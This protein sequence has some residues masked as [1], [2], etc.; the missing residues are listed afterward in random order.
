MVLPAAI[1]IRRHAFRCSTRQLVMLAH[2]DSPGHSQE[3]QRKH[4]VGMLASMFRQVN[5]NSFAW[6]HQCASREHRHALWARQ[7]L[8]HLRPRSRCQERR[9]RAELRADS[10]ACITTGPCLANLLVQPNCHR[11]PCQ[12]CR[13]PRVAHARCRPHNNRRP[14][15]VHRRSYHRA[16]KDPPHGSQ[17]YMRSRQDSPCLAHRVVQ[18]N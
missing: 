17:L 3:G 13:P 18:P 6:Q 11:F 7:A 10:Q 12:V 15:R 2:L 9:P 5:H 8:G 4:T 16:C 14:Q 1:L